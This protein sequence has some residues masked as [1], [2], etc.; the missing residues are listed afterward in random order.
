MSQRPS[1]PTLN[2]VLSRWTATA[3]CHQDKNW[4]GLWIDRN[5]RRP[6]A[7]SSAKY[8]DNPKPQWQAQLVWEAQN[9]ASHHRSLHD[10]PQPAFAV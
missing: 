5:R 1:L 8:A 6:K 4:D 3:A 9:S 2:Q 10:L 7:K